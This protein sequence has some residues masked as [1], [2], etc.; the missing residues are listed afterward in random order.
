M[1]IFIGK[2]GKS[3]QKNLSRTVNYYLV[4]SQTVPSSVLPMAHGKGTLPCSAP[5]NLNK[6]GSR[7][8]LVLSI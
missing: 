1:K 7:G 2:I 3:L 4:S 8:G 5:F 6:E